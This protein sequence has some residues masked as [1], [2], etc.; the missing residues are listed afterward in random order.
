MKTKTKPDVVLAALL[1]AKELLLL[2]DPNG[3]RAKN[4]FAP[5]DAEVFMLCNRVGFGAVMDSASRQWRTKIDMGHIGAH[6]CG[7]CV[8]SV[9]RGLKMVDSALRALKG[10]K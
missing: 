3:D 9:Q 10:R 6:A 2:C 8:G 7:P 4:I 5:E 1:E